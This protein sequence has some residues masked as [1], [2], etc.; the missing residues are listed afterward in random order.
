MKIQIVHGNIVN[1]EGDAIVNAGNVTL[2]GGGGV[3]GSIHQAA[4]P[5]LR[6]WCRDLPEIQPGVRCHTGEAVMTPGFKLKATAVIHTVGPI[7]SDIRTD[8][9]L[10]HGPEGLDAQHRPVSGTPFELLKESI[11]SCLLLAQTYH[12][13][14]MAMPAIS[15]G[16][17]GGTIPVFAKA[18]HEV[19][20]ENAWD[21]NSLT[22]YL[23][24]EH[25]LNDFNETW[26][27]LK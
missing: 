26:F 1:F 14:T 8:R 20:S 10:R 19:V 4:G 17:F 9:T 25:D 7:F 16:V 27:D 13:K 21:V 12:I 18:L 15:C 11:R 5:E 22:I 2:L 23:F 6:A 3:D 24:S